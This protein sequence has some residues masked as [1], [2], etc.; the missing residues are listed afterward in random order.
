MWRSAIQF[1]APSNFGETAFHGLSLGCEYFG[2]F[3]P[4]LLPGNASEVDLKSFQQA[5]QCVNSKLVNRR[6]SAVVICILKEDWEEDNYI[7]KMGLHVL[8]SVLFVV[9]ANA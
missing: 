1:A 7:S 5:E 8:L 6:F 9:C 2:K 4:R 3:T